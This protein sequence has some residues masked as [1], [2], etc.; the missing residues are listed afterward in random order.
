MLQQPGS[1]KSIPWLSDGGGQSGR[2][3]NIRSLSE[4]QYHPQTYEFTPTIT[5]DH[6]AY[7]HSSLVHHSLPRFLS[8]AP[9]FSLC[10]LRLHYL[11]API[12]YPERKLHCTKASVQFRFKSIF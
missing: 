11:S 7:F 6:V 9:S 3:R 4:Q 10:L 5:Y 2:T 8:V 1:V 12:A